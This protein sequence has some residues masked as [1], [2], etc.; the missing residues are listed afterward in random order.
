MNYVHNL[1]KD[2]KKY[3]IVRYS[4]ITKNYGKV[5]DKMRK[6]NL[7]IFQDEI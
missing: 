5:K 7:L 1:V 4:H 6:K 2:S 3:S